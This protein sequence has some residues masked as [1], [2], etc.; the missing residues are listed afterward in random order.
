[1]KAEAHRPAP[2]FIAAQP[3]VTTTPTDG[4]AGWT[5]LFIMGSASID[6]FLLDEIPLF[7][8]KYSQ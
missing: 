8:Q 4:V 5:G 3:G 6:E 7:S 2:I 1:M